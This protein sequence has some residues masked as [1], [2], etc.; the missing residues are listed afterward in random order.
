MSKRRDLREA[1][2]EFLYFWEIARPQKMELETSMATL[3]EAFELPSDNM[4]FC[5]GLIVGVL[6][7]AEMIDKALKERLEN[8][9]LSRVHKVDLTIL[10][11]AVYE[12]FFRPD[13]PPVVTINEAVDLAKS[14]SN[15]ESGHFINGIL[16]KIAATLDRPL[17]EAAK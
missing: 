3:W 17:R 7:N 6:Q 12:F 1:V 2:V 16:D 10:R 13:I 4:E 15:E 9:D 14:F 8:W 11:L 5:R